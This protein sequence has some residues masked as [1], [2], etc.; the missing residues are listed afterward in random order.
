MIVYHLVSFYR[1][2]EQLATV[3]QRL[4]SFKTAV[5]RLLQNRPGPRVRHLLE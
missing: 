1:E 5:A 4:N 3:Y 2:E